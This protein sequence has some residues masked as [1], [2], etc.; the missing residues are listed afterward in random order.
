[1]SSAG[2]AFLDTLETQVR[3]RLKN[4][5]KNM[6]TSQIQTLVEFRMRCI[7]KTMFDTANEQLRQQEQGT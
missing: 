3:N 4:A 2:D 7:A 6:A 1:M 5:T